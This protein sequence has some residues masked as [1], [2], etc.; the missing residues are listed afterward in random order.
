MSDSRIHLNIEIENQHPCKYMFLELDLPFQS[1]MCQFY[2][3][4]RILCWCSTHWG[5]VTH[6]C[7]SELTIIGSDNGLSPRH[8][9]AIIWNNA[10]WLL[11]E[12]IGTNVSETSIIIQTF[13]F[14]KMHLNMSSVKWR[15]FCLGLNVLMA[16]LCVTKSTLCPSLGIKHTL[17][18]GDAWIHQWMRSSL[19]K[20]I[21]CLFCTKPFPKPILTSCWLDLQKQTWW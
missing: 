12:P 2:V 18:S 13:S 20:V 15:P 4:I 14:K 5:R 21:S 9:Q 17:R 10:G 11:I 3:I 16:I 1:F 6:I 19:I 8:R 7:V